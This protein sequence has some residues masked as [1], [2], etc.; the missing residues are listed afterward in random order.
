MGR[1]PRLRIASDTGMPMM[2]AVTEPGSIPV[3]YRSWDEWRV[4][5]QRRTVEEPIP[6]VP[7]S[8]SF[9][10]GCWG[11]GRTWSP[12]RNGEG[13]IPVACPVCDGEGVVRHR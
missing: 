6:L 5:R 7:A 11:Q 9:C 4:D 2:F 12:A 10:A 8:A 1:E 13:L 3:A